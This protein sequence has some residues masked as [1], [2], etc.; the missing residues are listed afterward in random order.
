MF[1]G[2]SLRVLVVLLVLLGTTDLNVLVSDAS[3]CE[4]GP[5]SVFESRISEAIGVILKLR[6][7]STHNPEVGVLRAPSWHHSAIKLVKSFRK[8]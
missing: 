7:D 6:V 4:Y 8:K 5:D 2:K 3:D 1:R